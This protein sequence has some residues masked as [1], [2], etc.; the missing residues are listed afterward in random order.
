LRRREE[1]LL[2]ADRYE[3]FIGSHSYPIFARKFCRYGLAQFGQPG[4]LRVRDVRSI[5][6][7]GRFAGRL[8]VSRRIKVRG[9]RSQ[10]YDV[11]P[12]RTQLLYAI[13]HHDR[14][15]RCN[16]GDPG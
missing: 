15:R 11:L 16:A 14:C 1:S 7:Y 3:D 2:D 6:V 4:A 8:N 10:P 5:F 9:A 12:C 13:A